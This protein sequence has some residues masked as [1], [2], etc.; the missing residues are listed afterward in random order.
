MDSVR[1]AELDEQR[2][3]LI[4]SELDLAFTFLQ[5][6]ESTG[7]RKVRERY[8]R[9][10]RKACDEAEHLIEQGLVCT[11]LLLET[12]KSDLPWLETRLRE[13]TQVVS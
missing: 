13:Q 8:I 5:A 3:D 11:G 12:I 2:L 9:S 1:A 10:A 4:Q 7:I 6:A